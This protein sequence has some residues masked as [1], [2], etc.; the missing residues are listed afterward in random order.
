MAKTGDTGGNWF[1]KMF[2]GTESSSSKREDYLDDRKNEEYDEYAL[3]YNKQADK[4]GEMG[5][6]FFDPTSGRN[7]QQ[8]GMLE[9]A[10][11]DQTAS[12]VRD[13]QASMAQQG[14]PSQSGGIASQN[15]LQSRR[16]A[17]GDSANAMSAAYQKSFG[18]GI[19][20]HKMG[21]NARGQAVNATGMSDQIY[22]GANKVKMQQDT[23][24]AQKK[25][26]FAQMVG[27]A[28]FGAMAPG[29]ARGLSGMMTNMA[30]KYG[31]VGDM[32]SGLAA[33]SQARYGLQDAAQ[34]GM[35]DLWGSDAAATYKN[36]NA[37]HNIQSFYGGGGGL[38][39]YASGMSGYPQQSGNF[40]QYEG[41]EAYKNLGRK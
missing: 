2:L 19:Q 24:N 38:M 22:A 15:I 3:N 28:A 11:Q 4:F 36:Q 30:G 10:I 7:Q 27:G 20:A 9:S 1:S 34:Q 40:P 26:G 23:T 6:E 31:G 35:T 41:M 17:G 21:S 18:M 12:G 37:S 14:G 25:A 5:D 13:W 32:M 33:P 29:M 39:G 8:Y 16:R